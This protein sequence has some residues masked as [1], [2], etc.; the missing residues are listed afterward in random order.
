MKKIRE[1]I[2]KET[3][4]CVFDPPVFYEAALIGLGCIVLPNVAEGNLYQP[5]IYISM[6]ESV[7]VDSLSVF[8]SIA[9]HD[10][11]E[12][13]VLTPAELFIFLLLREWLLFAVDPISC[14]NGWK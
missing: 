8:H 11:A 5:I 10:V 2:V 3:N 6:R 12:S 9:A 4:L 14:R 13:K 1:E 7:C